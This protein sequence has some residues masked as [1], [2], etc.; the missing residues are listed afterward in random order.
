MNEDLQHFLFILVAVF[1]FGIT[2]A[3]TIRVAWWILGL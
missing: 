2:V 3:T 1:L